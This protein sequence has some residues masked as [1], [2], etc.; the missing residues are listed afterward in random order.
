MRWSGTPTTTV[1][2]LVYFPDVFRLISELEI[3]TD[4]CTVGVTSSVEVT[5]H[6]E[7]C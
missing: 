4:K 6:P 5:L 2:R 1:S 7:K 3:E